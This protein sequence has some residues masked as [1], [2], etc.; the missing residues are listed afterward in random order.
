MKAC[1]AKPAID[2]VIYLPLAMQLPSALKEKEEQFKGKAI[3]ETETG[4]ARISPQG[5]I[6]IRPLRHCTKNPPPPPNKF[7][8]TMN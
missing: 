8:G 1:G 7:G 3:P 2:P 6:P 4:K 5:T